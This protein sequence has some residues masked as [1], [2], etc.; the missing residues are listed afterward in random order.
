MI[1]E[2]MRPPKGFMA[3][4]RGE[5]SQ[6]ACGATAGGRRHFAGL[7]VAPGIDQMADEMFANQGGVY[8]S[9][10]RA[11]LRKPKPA[12]CWRRMRVSARR[13]RTIRHRVTSLLT[14]HCV[15]ASIGTV[16]ARR[17]ATGDGEDGKYGD[18]QRGHSGFQCC[19]HMICLCL[20][21]RFSQRTVP[22]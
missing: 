1:L 14:A 8:C 15:H 5:P 13:H 12:Q 11:T 22:T 4:F 3:S 2:M 7:W 10:L 9:E 18:A 21:Y 17:L 19:F 6:H 16:I 20:I